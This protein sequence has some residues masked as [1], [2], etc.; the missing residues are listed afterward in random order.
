[1]LTL[2]LPNH[3]YFLFVHDYNIIQNTIY[4]YNNIVFIRVYY[5]ITI[6]QSLVTQLSDCYLTSTLIVISVQ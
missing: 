3:F 6:Q 2:K 1:M 4:K 5:M